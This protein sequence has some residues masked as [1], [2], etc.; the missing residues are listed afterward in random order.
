MGHVTMNI[1]NL[2][3]KIAF[4]NTY[5]S[6]AYIKFLKSKNVEI[7]EG[8]IFYSPNTSHVDTQ[9][10]HMLHIGNYV[11]VTSGV[12]ILCHDY[13]RSVMCNLEQYGNVGE[14]KETWIGNNVFIGVNS[15]IL[16]GAHIGDNTIIGAGA[17][18][19][20]SYDDNVVIAGNPAKVVSTLDDFY[21]KRKKH[22]LD[23]AKEYVSS[24]KR[25]FGRNP[26]IYEMTNAF[27]WLYLPRDKE[28]IEE[29]KKLFRLNGI[30]RD[31][32]IDTFL[33]TKP[34]YDSFD[35]FL[36]DCE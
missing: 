10:P 16:M 27:S 8:C 24:W 30:D 13:S 35:A 33:H 4:P 3:M 17:V 1:R 6:E 11:K 14:A 19:S 31:Q 5:S 7:G 18:V 29:H 36:K 22:E 20:G 15:V 2:I 25:R 21:N 12:Q 28:T 26:T 9:R 23:A 32:Y 34:V